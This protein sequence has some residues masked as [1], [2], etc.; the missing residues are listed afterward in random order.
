[1]TQPTR[2]YI[3]RLA[4]AGV[5]QA[6]RDAVDY[7]RDDKDTTLFKFR[8]LAP[9]D[10]LPAAF[11]GHEGARRTHLGAKRDQLTST[12]TTMTKQEI[13]NLAAAREIILTSTLEADLISEYVDAIHPSPA[14]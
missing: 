2:T 3:L 5:T 10:P 9:G 14:V 1:M 8:G 13:L 4:T 7:W 6:M 12:L 11:A